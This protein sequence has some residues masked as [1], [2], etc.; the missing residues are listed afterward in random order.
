MNVGNDAAFRV[1][2]L[3]RVSETSEAGLLIVLIMTKA[4]IA[5]GGLFDGRQ[6]S[7]GDVETG[8]GAGVLI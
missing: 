3:A 7:R 2:A 6:V 1:D 5:C 4:I 8:A